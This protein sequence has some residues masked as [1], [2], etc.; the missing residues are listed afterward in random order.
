L[1]APLRTGPLPLVAAVALLAA[2]AP[3][4]HAPASAGNCTTV[5]AAYA[6]CRCADRC[7]SWCVYYL[8]WDVCVEEIDALVACAATHPDPCSWLQ[9]E[10]EELRCKDEIAA[11]SLCSGNDFFPLPGVP[12]A[13]FTGDE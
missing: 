5:C 7:S 13:C 2:C 11:F 1:S 10:P 9:E 8:G 12:D 6:G 4:P 3:S